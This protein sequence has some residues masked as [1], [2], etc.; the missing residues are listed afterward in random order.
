MVLM[1]IT[2][3]IIAAFFISIN[4]LMNPNGTLVTISSFIPFFSPLVA[5]S[6]FVAGEMNSIE[7]I[8]SILILIVTIGII[9]RIASR[10]YVNGVMFY[11]E[12]VKWKDIARLVKRQ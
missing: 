9:T 10:I 4:A 7:I 3:L 1:P 5:F 12:K 11:S 2:F 6:R 8:S